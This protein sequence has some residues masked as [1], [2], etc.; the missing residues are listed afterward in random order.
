MNLSEQKRLF[1]GE[2]EFERDSDRWIPWAKEHGFTTIILYPVDELFTLERMGDHV[3][4]RRR[5]LIELAHQYQLKIEEGGFCLSRFLPR[6]LYMNNRELFRMVEGRRVADINFC[7]TNPDTLE[8]VAAQARRFFQRRSDQ[9]VFHLWPDKGPHE[10]WCS[11]PTC[12]A[13]TPYEQSLIAINALAA[14]LLDT[15]STAHLSYLVPD[16][17]ESTIRCR[18]NMFPLPFPTGGPIPD[19]DGWA[20]AGPRLLSPNLPGPS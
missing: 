6:R 9:Q 3:T 16:N 1:I 8:I 18:P 2:V 4:G 14:I 13:F 10:G 20:I 15:G 7:P 17:T 11:C 19:R 5:K 12:R